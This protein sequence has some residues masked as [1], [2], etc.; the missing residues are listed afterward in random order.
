VSNWS[1]TQIKALETRD[2]A[3]LSTSAIQGLNTTQISALTASQV[4]AL[5]TTQYAALT[6]TQI[7]SLAMATPI[8]LDLNG[9]GINTLSVK[10]GVKFDILAN[11]SSIQTGWVAPQDGLLVADRNQDGVINDGSELF[12][13]S[14]LLNDGTKALDGYQAL[15]QFDSNSDG[16]V[17]RQDTDFN[18]LSVWTDRNSDG[19]T[20]TGELKTL[21]ELGITQLSVQAEEVRESNAGNLVGLK[22][23]Y[24][25]ADGNQHASA[26]V[27]FVVDKV[28]KELLSNHLASAISEFKDSTLSGN[29]L[30]L[31]RSELQISSL[32]S[33]S[34]SV[35]SNRLTKALKDY[36]VSTASSALDAIHTIGQ[37]GEGSLFAPPLDGVTALEKLNS[38]N[39]DVF[40]LK[41]KSK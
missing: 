32:Q 18:K 6:T 10:A 9:D 24:Q 21:A 1:A 40:S 39:P 27:W 16:V 7:G 17:N 11:G 25:T 13:S 31:D 3:V 20:E 41:N 30:N 15:A 4:C 5:T 22:S 12:G 19:A 37:K 34:V 35:N 8:V 2:L 36:Q 23:T 28:S 26:D 33:S 38:Q 29:S 14:T